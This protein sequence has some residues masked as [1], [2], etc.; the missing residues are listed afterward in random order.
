MDDYLRK[1]K[2]ASDYVKSRMPHQPVLSMVLG[3][4]LGDLAEEI[5]NAVRIP[6]KEIPHLP[7]S[8]VA[9]HAGV[10]VIGE[11]EGKKV[12]ALQ[13]R[14]HFYEG[15]SMKEVT[16]SVRVINSLGINSYIVTNAAGGVNRNFKAGD[17]MLMTDH[18]NNMGDNPLYGKNYDELGP[19]FP[20]MTYAYDREYMDIARKAA[21]S[22]GIDLKEGVYMANRGPTYETPAEVRFAAAVG[23]DAVGMSTIPEV[24]VAVH[25]G[26]RVLGISCITNIAAGILDQPLS[27]K[28]VIETTMKSKPKFIKLMREIIREI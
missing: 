26:M 27:H 1:V 19:R 14:V 5:Q 18:I 13:G 17:L 8:G 2:E 9:G 23:A 21:R 22:L 25:M 10:M 4:G 28:E 6:Y 20:D 7:V 15:Y 16:F 12:L 24:I 3:S 11:L